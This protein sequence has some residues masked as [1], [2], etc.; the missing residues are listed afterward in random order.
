MQSGT[1]ER[2]WGQNNQRYLTSYELPNVWSLWRCF[3]RHPCDKQTVF[4]GVCRSHSRGHLYS[5]HWSCK[6]LPTMV[7]SGPY[8]SMYSKGVLCDFDDLDKVF[9]PYTCDYGLSCEVFLNRVLMNTWLLHLGG[10]SIFAAQP[11]LG[12]C[13]ISF[14]FFMSNGSRPC[15]FP[16]DAAALYSLLISVALL[17]KKFPIRVINSGSFNR[18][19]HRWSAAFQSSNYYEMW[20]SSTSF[21]ASWHTRSDRTCSTASY[22]TLQISSG[23]RGIADH[24]SWSTVSSMMFGIYTADN[25]SAVLSQRRRAPVFLYALLTL[26]RLFPFCSSLLLRVPR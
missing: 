4:Q 13:K 9:W 24:I 6:D 22:T 1:W 25:F 23:A 12:A 15:L 20:S 7:L 8:L 10:C 21:N 5:D 3:L 17:G 26:L 2:R 18:L 11:P 16:E 19:L 14:L